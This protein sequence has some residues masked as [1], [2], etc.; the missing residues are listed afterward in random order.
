MI[1]VTFIPAKDLKDKDKKEALLQEITSVQLELMDLY[2]K[3][4]NP[5]EEVDCNNILKQD[6]SAQQNPQLTGDDYHCN[7]LHD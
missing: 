2:Q 6:G 4:L 1:N 5:S 3:M 7:W